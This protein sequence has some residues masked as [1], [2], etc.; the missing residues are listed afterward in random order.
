MSCDKPVPGAGCVDGS[1]CAECG[2][3]SL[4]VP[5]LPRCQGVSLTPGTFI[6]ATVTVDNNG[7]IALVVSGPAPQYPDPD[8]CAPVGGGTGGTGGRGPKGD[9]GPAATISVSPTV[10]TGATWA[11]T[12]IGTPSAAVIQLTVPSSLGSGGGGGGGVTVPPGA[13]TADV[14][15]IETT[16]G[17]VT[18]LP[19]S[20]VTGVS[21]LPL[22]DA[23][24]NLVTCTIGPSNPANCDVGITIDVRA[25]YTNI[26]GLIATAA[27]AL[28]LQIDGLTSAVA[29]LDTRIDATEASIA[30]TN[31]TVDTLWVRGS[32]TFLW[33]GGT[34]PATVTIGPYGGIPILTTAVAANSYISLPGSGTVTAVLSEVRMGGKLIHMYDAQP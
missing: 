10:A 7:C 17:W 24:N 31:A 6:N 34:A 33:N 30:Q 8:C 12:N 26:E 23:V 19:A 4:P 22:T 20:I 9:P 2:D 16:N 13:L 15:G 27:D 5:V 29:A 1:P 14:C 21:Y 18:G 28:Q 11:L 3:G 25:L 32:G